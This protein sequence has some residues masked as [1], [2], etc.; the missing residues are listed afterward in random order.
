MPHWE[1]NDSVSNL[2]IKRVKFNPKSVKEMVKLKM[3]IKEAGK[4]KDSQ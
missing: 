4:I 1:N 2:K 3:R